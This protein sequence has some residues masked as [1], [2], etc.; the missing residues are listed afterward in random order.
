[1]RFIVSDYIDGSHGF[2]KWK[3][4][5][6]D[7]IR[8]WTDG[9][10][11][12]L[13]FGYSIDQDLEE[14]IKHNPERIKDANGKFCV[15]MLWKDKMQVWVDYFCQTKVY[16][17]TRDGL[18]VTNHLPLLPLQEQDI[19]HKS[20]K[21]FSQ[22]LGEGVP[23]Y[24]CKDPM[25]M[26]YMDEWNKFS[27]DSTVFLHTASIPQDHMLEHD[28]KGTH[29]KRIHNTQE[30]NLQALQN[31]IVWNTAQL[32]D[33]IH[34]CMT[35][36]SAVIKR[37]YSNICSSVSEGID[38]TLQDQYFEADVRLMYHPEDSSTLQELPPKQ[39]MIKQYQAKDRD[40]HFDIF[41]VRDI[42]TITDNN[43]NDP[44]LS[45]MDTVPTAWQVNKLK[46]KPD[47]LLYGQCADEMFM[48][49]PNFLFARV[50]PPHRHRY[51]DSYGGRKS[52]ARPFR[53]PYKGE[54]H[55]D[56]IQRFAEMAVPSLYNRDVE[57]Q[58]NVLTTS[59]Y[60]DR[61]IFNLVHQMP[62]DVQLESMA[63]VT[64]QRNILQNRFAFPFHTKQKDGAG[65]ECRMVLKH[66][67]TNT[68]QRCITKCS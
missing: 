61:R 64:P 1:M 31:K 18:T 43:T 9:K 39:D 7:G 34:E 32:E 63:H 20:I 4:T 35:Q 67:M 29:I 5:H 68:L 66:L 48:H 12:C 45:Y 11:L 50:P 16:Y 14:I 56:W 28:S 37:E 30:E 17:H 21:R 26:K 47:L 6:D 15:I 25:N 38:S 58:T 22:G 13:W 59:L 62:A 65:Y 53:D 41:D 51:Q 23:L 42:G 2:G 24:A 60:A 52:P 36:H 40:I 55:N 54:W 27:S 46:K 33:R 57:N 19:D 49:V 44:M 8:S 3:Y 10:R